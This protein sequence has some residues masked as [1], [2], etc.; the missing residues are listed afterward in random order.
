MKLYVCMFNSS[1]EIRIHNKPY[2]KNSTYWERYVCANSADPDQTAP[3]RSSLIRV[4]TVNHSSCILKTYYC[5][6]KPICSIF[7]KTVWP[8]NVGRYANFG[9]CSIINPIFIDFVETSR[10]QFIF[11][12][13]FIGHHMGSKF[14]QRDQN[15]PNFRI[16]P[17]Y[18]GCASLQ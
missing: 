8:N 17:D 13:F 15:G 12:L 9:Y 3:T 18:A 7:R 10:C 14:I 5:I 6:V 2:H 4:H 11:S 1:F 16:E